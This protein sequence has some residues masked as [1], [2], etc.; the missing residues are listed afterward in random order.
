MGW[1]RKRLPEARLCHFWAIGQ[2]GDE[3]GCGGGGVPDGVV[4]PSGEEEERGG[5]RTMRLGRRRR[6]GS[7]GI[8][9]R[10][11]RFAGLIDVGP[12]E[13]DPGHRTK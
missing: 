1:L 2:E 11:R 6:G 7:E 5:W 12:I 10:G 8:R 13:R 9:C 4:D 3:G